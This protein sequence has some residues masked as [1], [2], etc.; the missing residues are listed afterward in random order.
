MQKFLKEPFRKTFRATVFLVFCECGISCRYFGITHKDFLESLRAFLTSFFW[1]TFSRIIH[2]S[3]SASL[4]LLL[5]WIATNCTWTGTPWG[6]W[7]DCLINNDATCGNGF[8][9]REKE[10]CLC[11]NNDVQRNNSVCGISPTQVKSCYKLC[12]GNYCFLITMQAS[13][14]IL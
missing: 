3:L 11:E 6:S 10:Y 12:A 13:K 2:F 7:E 4:F 8:Q 14:D 5:L 9:F 1:K